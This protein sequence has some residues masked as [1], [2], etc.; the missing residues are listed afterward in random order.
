MRV[1]S[2]SVKYF[3][4]KGLDLGNNYEDYENSEEAK[5]LLPDKGIV[6]TLYA[7]KECDKERDMEFFFKYRKLRGL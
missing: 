4:A 2:D 3:K 6:E 5:K 7:I 1:K